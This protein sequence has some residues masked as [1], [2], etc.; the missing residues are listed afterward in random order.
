MDRSNRLL[1]ALLAAVVLVA[2]P[3]CTCGWLLAPFVPREAICVEAPYSNPPPGLEGT[4]L[5]GKWE[6]RYDVGVDQLI[7]RADGTFKQIYEERI[8]YVVRVYSY[9]TPWNH[10]WVEDTAD[11]GVRLHLEGARYYFR[12]RSIAQRDGMSFPPYA[13][14]W[15][16][17]DPFADEYMEM[18]RKLTLGIRADS[19]GELLLHHMFYHTD[20]G[21]TMT[22]CQKE[23]FRRIEQ[24]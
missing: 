7:L 11:G 1:V 16:F 14:P 20:E 9:Q 24:P 21:F 13:M 4:D 17:Y 15:D 5:A 18:V 10:W 6:A 2:A 3:A 19:A 23:H 22:G 8:G 12:G